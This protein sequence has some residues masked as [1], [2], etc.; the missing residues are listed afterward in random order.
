MFGVMRPYLA[1]LALA[2]V[3]CAAHKPPLAEDFGDLAGADEKSDKFS[4]RMSFVGTIEYGQKVDAT[5]HAPPRYA[6]LRLTGQGGDRVVADVRAV[7]RDAVAWL[8]DSAF[9]VLAANDDASPGTFD[10]HLEATLPGAAQARATYYLIFREYALRDAAFSILLGGPP[11]DA[12]FWMGKSIYFVVT[13]RFANGD[14]SN[15]DAD[16]FAADLGDA[17][18]WHGGDFAGLMDKLD[19]VTGMGFD[20]LWLTPVVR[21]HDAHAYHGYWGWD[22]TQVDGHLGGLADLQA[23]VAAAHARGLSVM[24]DTVANHTGRYAYRSPTFPDPAMYHHNGNITDWNDAVQ[25]ETFDVNG[26][27][28][29]DQDHP[30]VRETLLDHARWLIA[31]TGADGLRLDTV[32][33]VPKAFWRAYAASAGVFTIG[34]VLSPDVALVSPYTHEGIDATLDYPLYY[35]ARSAFT[36]NGSARAL[37]AVLADDD[38]YADA[39]SSGVFV[40]NHDQ[41]RFLCLMKSATDEERSARLAAALTFTFTVRGIP[42]LY[43]GTEQGFGDCTNNRQDMA[44]AFDPSQPVYQLVRRLNDLRRRVPA[45]R[46]GLQR[47]RWRDDAVYAFEREEGASAALVGVNVDAAA[48]TITV[49]HMRVPAG[50]VL[51]DVL[52]DGPAVTVD[53]AGDATITIPARSVLVLTN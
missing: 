49:H 30:V 3:G 4:S 47:E 7:G 31:S 2:V 43:Y 45:L 26:L 5:Y 33:H 11:R 13:D 37:G 29:L 39:R 9:H 44:G 25:L 40:D 16:G 21:Q 36:E 27:N 24:I 51:S 23:L 8:T 18:A 22:L 34:E 35:A 28:D 12:G 41:P 14:R 48:H 42:I 10:A 53:G 17:N 52:S 19:Y 15:D 32:K 50:T 46:T 6:A 1:M 20:A 38:R